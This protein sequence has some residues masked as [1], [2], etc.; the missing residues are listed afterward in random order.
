M[1]LRQAAATALATALLVFLAARGV[2][3]PIGVLL[4]SVA[5]LSWVVFASGRLILRAVGATDLPLVAAWPLG[6]AAT[7]AAI[8]GTVTIA[9]V[10]AAT[11][12]APW[13]V[14]AIVADLALARRASPGTATARADLVGI[15]LCAALTAAWCRELAA[16]PAALGED[17]PLHAWIDYFIHGGVISQFGDSRAIGRGAIWLA[18][19]PRPLY[20]YASYM[21]PAALAVP[22]DQP[23][24]PLATSLWV[25]IGFFSLAAG[26]YAL[27]ASLAGAAGGVAA[28]VALFVVPDASNYWLRNGFFSFHWNMLSHPGSTYALGTAL[29]AVAFLHRWTAARSRGAFAASLVLVA[30]TFLFRVHVFLLLFPAWLAVVAVASRTVQRQ[31]ALFLAT[32]GIVAIAVVAG[33]RLMPE[34]PLGESWAFDQGQALERFLHQVHERQEP[35]AYE[36]LYRRILDAHGEAVGFTA[37][38]LLV[39]LAALG[40]FA[41]LFPA[42]M[43]LVRD[44]LQL[45]GIDAFPLALLLCYALIMLL[46]PVPSHQD[47][48]DLTHRPF[49]MLYAALAVWTA[50]AFVHWLSLRG[51]HGEDRLWQSAAVA[52]ALAL[53]VV[54]VLAAELGRPKFGWSWPLAKHSID[55]DLL[56]GASFLRERS[57]GGDTLATSGLTSGYAPI[58]APTSLVA[59]TATPAYLARPWYQVF[60]GGPRAALAIRRFNELKGIE[61]ASSPDA[62][63]LELRKLGVRWYVVTAAGAPSW[64]PARRRAVFTRGGVAIYDTIPR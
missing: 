59:L 15:A 31:R 13:A 32:G 46:A 2:S 48:T 49:V 1:I 44:R 28:L 23:G 9:P 58:D 34:L 53:P 41:V 47:A 5:V 54:W 56:A 60:L 40:A 42:A 21:L 25:P 62:A 26:S 38:V 63:M 17:G 14:L 18:D 57:R 45:R 10:T 52:C 33:L 20:H 30:A 4:A 35:T 19:F 6:V 11:A 8:L 43:L 22:L 24:L 36:G 61:R 39:Y 64:D 55:R 50:A 29:L 51:S 12:F 3:A 16:A 7:S 27:G 37:G